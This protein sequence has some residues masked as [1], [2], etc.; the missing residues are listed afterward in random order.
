MET[1]FDIG[2]L[3]QEKLF[4]VLSSAERLRQ[5]NIRVIKTLIGRGYRV[6]VI[7]TNQPSAILKKH[8]A[9]EGIDMGKVTFID[10]ITKYAIGRIPEGENDTKFVNSPSN[11]TDL[12]IAI[13]EVLNPASGEKTCL[14]FDSISTM[15][16]YLPSI[17]I[18]KFIHFVTSKLRLL[19]VPG[20]FL[21]VEKGIDPLLLTQLT[22]YVDDVIDMDRPPGLPEHESKPL[23]T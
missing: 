11:L 1:Q 22:T 21:A 23:G 4:L 6:V 17:H 3:G 18:S 14:L 12:G 7:T 15:L 16:I 13:T 20:I 9:A 2:R 19:D 10:A 8:Y 5:N